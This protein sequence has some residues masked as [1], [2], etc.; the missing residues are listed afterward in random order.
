MEQEP[1]AINPQR[2]WKMK[3]QLR[4]AR[5][6][7]EAKQK[8]LDFWIDKAIANGKRAEQLEVSANIAKITSDGYRDLITAKDE[9][10][11]KL[12][13]LLEQ[14]TEENQRLRHQ[15]EATA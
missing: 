11:D 15:Q 5:K 6:E 14:L 7:V 8:A 13:T 2:F 9:G 3:R 12:L 1:K 10:F 4:R